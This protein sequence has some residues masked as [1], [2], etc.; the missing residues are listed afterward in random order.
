LAL[1]YR[2]RTAGSSFMTDS[3]RRRAQNG[4]LRGADFQERRIGGYLTALGLA[5]ASDLFAAGVDIHGVYDWNNEIRN[6][7]PTYDPRTHGEAAHVAY[8]YVSDVD[9][10]K[11]H[12]SLTA[13]P[14][15]PHNNNGRPQK[16]D[17]AR[18]LRQ[19]L[20]T[21][22]I[23]GVLMR[24]MTPTLAVALILAV[25]SAGSTGHGLPA[26]PKAFEER[27]RPFLV[28]HCLGCHGGEKP[29]G[30]FRLD[31]LAPDFADEV[32][33]QRWLTVLER[34]KAGEMPPESKPRPAAKDVQLLA[35]WIR[36]KAAAAAAAAARRT[37]G[38]VVLRRLNR[39][40]YE[41]TV[42]DLLGVPVDL[43]E[44]LP[45][46]TSAHGFDNVGEALH[47]S[48]FLME[49]YL[50]AADTALNLAIAN[51]PQPPRTT[52]RYSLK[53]QHGVK[54][55]S[56][57][58]FRKLGD[59][60]V[61]FS[62]SPWQAV[63]LYE[64]YPPDRGK[65][66]FRISASGYQSS[67]KPVTYRVDAGLMGMVGKNHLVGYFD[68]PADKPA[69][70]E[71]VNHLEARSTIRIL[72]YGLAS[73]QAV[74]KVGADKYEGPG[75]AV[76]WVEVEGPLHDSWP[77]PSH[78]R[79]FGALAR[80]PVAGNRLEVVSKNPGADAE[81]LL[82]D[83]TR[84]GF[85]R[86]VTDDDVKPLL[87]LVKRKLAEKRSFEQAV[88]VGFMAAM[89]SPEFLFLREKPGKLDDFAFAARLSYF[90]WSTMPDQE[91]FALAEQRKLGH[92]DTL[93]RQVE[94]MLKDPKAAAFTENFVGQWLGLRDIDFTEP[95]P[96]LYPEFDDML[97]A[98]MVKETQLF[99]EEVL[100]NDLSLT[101]FVVSDFSM[102]N[103]R[104]A[105]HYGIPGVEGWQFRKVP[106][107]KDSHRGGV[108]T[109][110]SILKVTANG[111]TT[112]PVTRGT[113]ILE[114]ILGT[115]AP[116]PPADV[117]AIEPDIRGATTIREQL[118]KHR[119]VASCAACHAKIDPPGFA[120]ES[121][122]VIGGWRDHYRTTGRGEAVTADG[123]R[124][125]Y[126]KG[127][128]VDP[129]DTLPDGRRFANIDELK[130]LLLNDKEQI[131]RALTEKL[132]TYAT[133][134]APSS[135]DKPEIEAIVKK[136]RDKNYGLRTLVQEIVQSK[137][138]QNK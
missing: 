21:K 26:N 76:Q 71:F 73:A 47:V 112:S 48:S 4:R 127:P 122:D 133:G 111:T 132:L 94:R 5:R 66:R 87:A 116:R 49:R 24:F 57:S 10:A 105:K 130:Q 39:V 137:P 118:A 11:I 69:V 52:T 23:P 33:R 22:F 28:R 16:P 30:K 93:R 77:P 62:S 98:S 114:R 117:P 6:W 45:A 108:L 15:S 44:L 97:K 115:P 53:D 63:H 72:P 38:R 17:A 78:R 14:A 9:R 64:F 124:M 138:F 67:G 75:L 31:R 40:E 121:F 13:D 91:L 54:D 80:A 83:F 104:L 59:T 113:W 135:S 42:R 25:D 129:A 60:V 119:Q 92:P 102:L 100:K 29:K 95:S 107:P 101:N 1:E 55:P 74:H 128:K 136:L 7:E 88:R 79:L 96:L 8:V 32:S 126:L 82:R 3:V 18:C 36:G 19:R 58:V 61:L 84:R 99:F 41:N 125:P 27:I 110:A 81:R 68:A 51:G 2:D 90:L 20:A 131:S 89:V 35:D 120:L 65:Y 70:V 37:Q 56:E 46:D 86:A 50:E 85:R 12:G 134:A 109:M 43:K 123:R 34:V 103:G 106:L